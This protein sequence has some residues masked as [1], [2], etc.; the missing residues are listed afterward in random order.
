MRPAFSS[1]A[2]RRAHKGP[3]TSPWLCLNLTGSSQFWTC[4]ELFTSV[5]RSSVTRP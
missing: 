2:G 1:H 4:S 5:G 3:F